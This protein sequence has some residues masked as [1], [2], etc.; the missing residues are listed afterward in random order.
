[1]LRIMS[2]HVRAGLWV[3]YATDSTDGE[4]FLISDTFF[5]GISRGLEYVLWYREFSS[6][7]PCYGPDQLVVLPGRH[8]IGDHYSYMQISH[9]HIVNNI[10]N[11]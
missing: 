6:S 4:A 1:M 5:L 7:F 9:D 2:S 10:N 8:S 11:L 3:D